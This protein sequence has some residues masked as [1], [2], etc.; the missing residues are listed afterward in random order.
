MLVVGFLIKIFLICH[1]WSVGNATTQNDGVVIVEIFSGPHLTD[2]CPKGALL[3]FLSRGVIEGVRTG[4]CWV[5]FLVYV[6]AHVNWG[7]W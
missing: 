2:M 5:P 4:V 3:V 7:S 6:R 1:I